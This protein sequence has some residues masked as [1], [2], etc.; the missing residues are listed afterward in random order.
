MIERCSIQSSMVAHRG[1]AEVGHRDY[2]V[3]LENSIEP[4]GGFLGDDLTRLALEGEEESGALELE[5][6][7][8]LVALRSCVIC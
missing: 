4:K 5:E 1:S 3:G 2:G 6:V 7:R 8:R